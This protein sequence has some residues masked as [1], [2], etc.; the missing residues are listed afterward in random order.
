MSITDN[1]FQPS[2]KYKSK[3]GTVSGVASY[4]AHFGDLETYHEI[5]NLAEN[6]QHCLFWTMLVTEEDKFHNIAQ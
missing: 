2:L 3:A 4:S 5:L 1:N 6:E